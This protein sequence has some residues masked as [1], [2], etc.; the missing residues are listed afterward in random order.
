MF[1]L[2]YRSINITDCFS[3]WKIKAKKK[4]FWLPI[5]Y[6][7]GFSF[8]YDKNTQQKQLKG[9]EFKVM[10]II[11]E[12]SAS[13]AKGSWSHHSRSQETESEETGQR[14]FYTSSCALPLVLDM[15]QDHRIPHRH[16]PD[17]ISQM[18]PHSSGWQLR[19]SITTTHGKAHHNH[20]H[21]PPPQKY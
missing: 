9:A 4:N 6:L 20:F 3:R 1:C 11:R 17:S 18:I 2:F 12:G 21:S 8:G 14:L 5:I 13:G 15:M 16:H 7:G 19:L 10:S